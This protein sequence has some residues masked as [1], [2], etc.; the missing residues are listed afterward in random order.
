MMALGNPLPEPVNQQDGKAEKATND[1][2]RLANE[3]STKTRKTNGESNTQKDEKNSK[4]NSAE[5]EVVVSTE[6]NLKGFTASPKPDD[7]LLALPFCAPLSSMHGFKYRVKLTPGNLK[8]GK[9]CKTAVEVFSRIP[10]KSSSEEREKGLIK[11]VTDP[12]NVAVMVGGVKISAPGL[13][14][15][16]KSL[17][18]KSKKGKKQPVQPQQ[19]KKKKKKSK[20]KPVKK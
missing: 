2:S 7:V 3:I 15:A 20:T 13:A 4:V 9:A 1:E 10:S 18:G 16:S 12:N 17:K 5:D 11:S 14:K 19:D 8:K 6:L